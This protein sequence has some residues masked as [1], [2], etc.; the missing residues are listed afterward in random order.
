MGTLEEYKKKVLQG[1]ELSKKEALELAGMELE[2]L[3]QAAD[4]IRRHFMGDAFDMCTIINGKSGR[5]SEDCKYCAQSVYYETDIECYPLLPTEK[6]LEQA[7]REEAQGVLRYSIVT[8]GRRLTDQEVDQ[9]CEGIR[10][11]RE[12]TGLQVCVSLGLLDVDNYRKLKEAGASRVHNNLETSKRY[13]PQV[14]TTHSYQNKIMAIQ[15]AQEAGLQICSGGIM[16]LGESMEDRID[17]ACQL[18]ALEVSS[19]PVNML[20]PIPNTP[21]ADR[22]VLT[23]EEMRR[24]VAVYRFLLPKASIRLAGGRG[25]LPDLGKTCF[26]SGANAAISGDMLTTVGN[27][28]RKDRELVESLGYCVRLQ[29]E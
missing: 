8:S 1:Y 16:G 24:I 2:P 20:N 14:C 3:C 28:I 21:Y 29:N 12:E 4:E 5:C 17:M 13:F 7:K 10:R 9:L 18:R 27:T 26:C 11:I 22:P 25:L 23:E 6:L 15:A 19:V